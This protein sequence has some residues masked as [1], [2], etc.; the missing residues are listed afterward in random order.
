[1]HLE[2]SAITS[3]VIDQHLI[4]VFPFGV[5]VSDFIAGIKLFKDAIGALSD[6]RGARAD[7]AELS[8]S[9]V[10]LERSLQALDNVGLDT[11]Q[12]VQALK[13]TVDAC[14]LCLA[15]FLTDIAKFRQLNVQHVSKARLMAR[16]RQVQWSLCKKEDVRKFR[17]DVDTHIGALNML[18]ITFQ[19]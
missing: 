16:F 11:V 17:S 14:K 3:T 6:T 10:S 9:L 18:L 19:V 2:G 12:H 13:E 5:S 8:R 15:S 7:Y 1:M 4:M